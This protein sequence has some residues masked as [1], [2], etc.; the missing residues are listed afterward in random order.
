MKAVITK[1]FNDR[2]SSRLPGVNCVQFCEAFVHCLETADDTLRYLRRY[3]YGD[4]ICRVFE[5]DN[6]HNKDIYRV[7]ICDDIP[8]EI[9]FITIYQYDEFYDMK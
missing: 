6:P 3:R 1:H 2:I 5:L 4:E 9:R 8:G 7:V